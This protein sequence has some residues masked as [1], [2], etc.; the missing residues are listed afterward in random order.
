MPSTPEYLAQSQ[1]GRKNIP[2]TCIALFLCWKCLGNF[3]NKLFP[4]YI[5]YLFCT[6]RHMSEVGF[7]GASVGTVIGSSVGGGSNSIGS[8]SQSPGFTFG[9]KL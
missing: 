5:M 9:D 8:S 6:F 7:S 3:C 1:A 4:V 2:E